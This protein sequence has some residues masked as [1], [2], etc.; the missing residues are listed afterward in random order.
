MGA[1]LGAIGFFNNWNSNYD[2]TNG[3]FP[4]ATNDS[5]DQTGNANINGTVFAGYAWYLPK[6]TFL[7]V[8][9]FDNITNASSNLTNTVTTAPPPGLTQQNML[10]IPAGMTLDGSSSLTLENVYGVRALPGY[11]INQ[12]A[13]LYGIV[14]FARAHATSTANASLS[15]PSEQSTSASDS[16]NFNGYQLGLGSQLNL[17]DHLAIRTDIIFTLYGTQTLAN[18]T[19]SADGTDLHVETTAKPSTL[20]GNISLVYMF[21]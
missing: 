12:N 20:E 15:E 13:V 1:G 18:Q 17:N 21:G 6:S 3:D 19:V 9:V 2:A 10:T 11:Q 5:S 7:G 8:E 4:I 14:G 16:S